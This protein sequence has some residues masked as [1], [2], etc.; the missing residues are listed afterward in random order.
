MRFCMPHTHGKTRTFRL[1]DDS[2]GTNSP[3]PQYQTSGFVNAVRNVLQNGSPQAK[4]LTHGGR[5]YP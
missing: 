2:G 3:I 4:R 1:G 5:I